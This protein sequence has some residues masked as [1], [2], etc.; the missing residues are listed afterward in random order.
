MLD[1]LNGPLKLGLSNIYFKINKAKKTDTF[2][3]K[4]FRRAGHL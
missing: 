4:Q 1:R 3:Y 2:L